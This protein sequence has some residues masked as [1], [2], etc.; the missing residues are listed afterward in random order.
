MVTEIRIYFEGDA[1]LQP[2]LG[3]FLRG[4]REKARKNHIR[5]QL[6]AAGDGARVFRAF[7]RAL[8]QYPDA[9][10]I[11]LIDA[12]GPVLDPPWEHL[13]RHRIASR[14][15]PGVDDSHCHLMVQMMETWLLADVDALA[16]YYRQGFNRGAIPNQADVEKIDKKRVENALH[17]ATRNTAKGVYHKTR[18]AP[19]ILKLLNPEKLRKA[20]PHCDRLFRTIAELIEPTS[21]PDS[22]EG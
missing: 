14:R 12:E 9:F 20:S 8:D 17:D 13:L 4:F 10:I 3:E 1:A 11:L 6:T 19:D 22:G 2:A 16:N 21:P 7:E 18:H 15:L 5:W